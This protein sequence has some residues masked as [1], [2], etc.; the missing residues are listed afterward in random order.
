MTSS[1]N[2]FATVILTMGISF[3][4][5]G[6]VFAQNTQAADQPSRYFLGKEEKMLLPVNI[7]GMVQKPGQYMVPFRTDLISLI[8]YA[9]GFR[10]GAKINEIKI[11]RNMNNTSSK[12]NGKANGGQRKR[13]RVFKV[14]VKR[15]F[16]YGDLSQIPQLLPDDTVLVSGSAA[17]KV[18][19]VFDFVS[20]LVILGQLA[21][22]ITVVANQ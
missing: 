19:K 16:E 5:M 8:A 4:T 21:F 9:G 17:Q 6:T 7:L 12:S 15:Y 1:V 13:A 20:K 14:D 10:E 18:N 11:V 22:Y 2:S 3:V